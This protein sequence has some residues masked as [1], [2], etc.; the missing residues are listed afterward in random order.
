MVLFEIFSS[1]L[2]LYG[3]ITYTF[4]NEKQSNRSNDLKATFWTMQ[5]R[6]PELRDRNV[7]ASATYLSS[8]FPEDKRRTTSVSP[9]RP[10]V[11]QSNVSKPTVSRFPT[12][13]STTTSATKSSYYSSSRPSY[14]EFPPPPPVTA[15]SKKPICPTT[16]KTLS[17]VTRD[18][19]SKSPASGKLAASFL[20]EAH[21]SAAYF[22]F[23]FYFSFS[24]LLS[25]CRSSEATYVFFF[26]VLR[27]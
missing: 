26:F 24:F 13:S 4:T 19:K 21:S 16:K 12:S 17:K 3:A 14:A 5:Y 10:S 11:P 27:M 22:F 23:N 8:L 15:N 18:P 9:S 2:V 1:L 25:Q 7:A 20:L 6:D